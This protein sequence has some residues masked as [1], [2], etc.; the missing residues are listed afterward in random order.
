MKKSGF[1]LS[2]VLITLVIIGVISTIGISIISVNAEFKRT[3]A[4]IAKSFSVL[5]QANTNIKR[6]L[7]LYPA[8]CCAVNDSKCFGELFTQRMNVMKSKL[9][10]PNSE[11]KDDCWGNET[12]GLSNISEKH[13]CV[14]AADGI[15]YDF[16]Y[17]YS[18][19][20]FNSNPDDRIYGY[21]HIDINGPKKPNRWGKDRFTFF[22][23]YS[24]I[25][26]YDPRMTSSHACSY[27]KINDFFN[28][29]SCVQEY[30]QNNDN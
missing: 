16:D 3:R 11:K 30:L 27:G 4:A 15:I 7:G 9:Y 18:E 21:I 6:D 12:E 14:I 28:N 8:E 26:P 19:D 23:V 20:A 2:E 17:E 22:V 29:S 13:Y 24:K 10:T 5:T 25:Y 1:T